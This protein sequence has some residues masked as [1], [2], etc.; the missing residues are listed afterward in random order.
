MVLCNDMAPRFSK[1]KSIPLT[2][3]SS[4]S[5]LE[6]KKL[7]NVC[8]GKFLRIMD[9]SITA[10][11]LT[12]DPNVVLLM[13]SNQR[14]IAIKGESNN[15]YLCFNKK[16]EL[17]SRHKGRRKLCRFTETMNDAYTQLQSLYN[18]SWEVGFDGQGKL[19]PA[20]HPSS[21]SLSFNCTNNPEERFKFM[22]LTDR[23]WPKP[24]PTEPPGPIKDAKHLNKAVKKMEHGK[25][26]TTRRRRRRRSTRLVKPT[27]A[28]V[29]NTTTTTTLPTR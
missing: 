9:K 27:T 18:R 24:P 4:G 29:P 19:I 3:E 13:E 12:S 8:S 17:K 5:Y 2:G 25:K 26:T 6:R 10:D 14:G 1:V 7:Y 22:K 23:S 15:R 16:G 21:V 20:G 28:Q 11:G